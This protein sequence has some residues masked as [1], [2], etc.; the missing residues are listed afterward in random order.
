MTP[1][2]PPHG[3]SISVFFT[4]SFGAFGMLG[5]NTFSRIFLSNKA[6]HQEDFKDLTPQ[7]IV[8]GYL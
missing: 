3:H 2:P 5:A 7:D 1:P 4:K 8:C 6:L